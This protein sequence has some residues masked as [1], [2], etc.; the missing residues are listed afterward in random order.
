MQE[1]LAS[2]FILE[3]QEILGL[4]KLTSKSKYIF[5]EESKSVI[6]LHNQMFSTQVEI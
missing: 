2:S 1:S 4:E 5:L 6:E 3:W